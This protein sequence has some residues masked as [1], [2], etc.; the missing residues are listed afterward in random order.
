MHA[1]R[2]A[3]QPTLRATA[4]IFVLLLPLAA[5]S[6]DV[7]EAQSGQNADVDIRTP[8]GN[9]SVR[10]EVDVRDTGLPVYADARPAR[11]DDGNEKANVNIG[12]P[13]FGLK[14]VAANFESDD[15]PGHVIE[16]YRNEL[17]RYGSVTECK[18]EMDVDGGER[19]RECKGSGRSS[20]VSLIAG[21]EDRQR[22]V[23]VKPRGAGSEFALVYVETRGD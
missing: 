9:V 11:N 16:F 23:A 5:C 12:T 18:G 21:P 1:T 6:V 10:T 22:I 7:T 15:A 17:R 4:A 19:G 3:L 2:R 8:A 13:W 14:V 20:A